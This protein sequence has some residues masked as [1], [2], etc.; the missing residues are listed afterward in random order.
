MIKGPVLGPAY[1]GFIETFSTWRWCFYVIIIWSFL[2][3]LALLLGA[4]ETYSPTLLTQRARK[5][6]RT[7]GKECYYAQHEEELKSKSLAKTISTSGT[8]VFSL[9]ILEPMLFL[10]CLWCA[11]LLGILYLSFQ[12]YREY[13]SSMVMIS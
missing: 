13:F 2:G 12:L 5:L 9:L 8:R 10:L 11:L 3:W 1:G 4:P 7:T 6:R